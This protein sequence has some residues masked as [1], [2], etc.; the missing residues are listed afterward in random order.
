MA[1]TKG[2]PSEFVSV[3]SLAVAGLAARA[4]L[5]GRIL[6][7][8]FREQRLLQSGRSHRAPDPSG[9]APRRAA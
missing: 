4:A 3:E 8:L 5:Q 9:R 7:Q 1:G 2:A 6:F